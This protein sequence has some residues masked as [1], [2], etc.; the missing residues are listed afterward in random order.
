VRYPFERPD[1]S[2]ITERQGA[3]GECFQGFGPAVADTQFLIDICKEA[4]GLNLVLRLLHFVAGQKKTH[5]PGRMLHQF[6]RRAEIGTI[7]QETRLAEND[8]LPGVL[9]KLIPGKLM[10]ERAIDA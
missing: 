9:R 8:I 10:L 6:E 4:E 3:A 7:V 1:F 5:D 2:V